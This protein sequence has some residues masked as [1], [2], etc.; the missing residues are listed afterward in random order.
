[1][2]ERDVVKALAETKLWDT[3]QLDYLIRMARGLVRN[4]QTIPQQLNNILQECCEQYGVTVE[5]VKG[6]SRVL[7]LALCRLSYIKRAYRETPCKS[8]EIGAVINR[9][10]STVR[11]LHRN[12]QSS[13]E[14]GIC[15]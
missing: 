10:G 15:I 1:M 12:N 11:G 9:T 14:E 3:P 8:H 13:Y 7:L 2:T 5:A 4:H 6:P